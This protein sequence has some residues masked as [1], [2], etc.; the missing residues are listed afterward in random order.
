MAVIAI[1]KFISIHFGSMQINQYRQKFKMIFI[2][3]TYYEFKKIVKP[4]GLELSKKLRVEWGF[5]GEFEEILF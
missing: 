2:N 3:S 5:A 4:G 1:S